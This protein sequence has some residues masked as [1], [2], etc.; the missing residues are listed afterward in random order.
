MRLWI[1]SPA[2][3]GVSTIDFQWSS[4]LKILFLLFFF[5]K[6][7]SAGNFLIQG[8]TFHFILMPI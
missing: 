5:I 2:T 7:K 8:D 3:E 1:F 6:I 4:F